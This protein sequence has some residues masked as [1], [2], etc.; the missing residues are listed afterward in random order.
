M[1]RQDQ[2]LK[3]LRRVVDDL[4]NPPESDGIGRHERI[5]QHEQLPFVVPHGRRQRQS[6]REVELFLLPSRKRVDVNRLFD[7]PGEETCGL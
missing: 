7:P 5:V 2:N 1:A 3:L 6:D 4:E